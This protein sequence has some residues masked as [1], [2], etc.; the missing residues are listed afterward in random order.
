V[1]AAD[2]D[3]AT[4]LLWEGG[5]QGI[6]VQSSP[7]GTVLLAYFSDPADVAGALRSLP[8]A[9]VESVPVPD[10]DWVKNFREGFRAFDVGPFRVVPAWEPV[11]DSG[12]VLRVDPARAFGTGTHETTRLCLDALA[13]LA[14]ERTLG[15]V[16]DLGAG[17]GIL[18]VAAARLRARRVAATDLDLE[19]TTS[20]RHHARLNDVEILVVQ[21]DGG[22]AFKPGIFDLVLA[23]LTAPLLVER[24]GEI[25]GLVAAGGRLVLSGLLETEARDVLTT[26]RVFPLLSRSTAG[27][28]AA[29]ELGNAQ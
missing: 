29:L 4:A 3:V 13:R 19:A 10:V 7:E 1:P 23:N 6:E 22:R 9:R 12:L 21:A 18:A 2:E 11:P 28:W 25:M 5:T 8:A 26:Y 15:R 17:T 14:G 16:L 20:I 27:E 24:A